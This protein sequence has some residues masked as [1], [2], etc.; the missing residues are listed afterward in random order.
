[1]PPLQFCIMIEF[2]M[3]RSIS[4]N[5]DFLRRLCISFLLL[6]LLYASTVTFS[7]TSQAA[8]TNTAAGLTSIRSVSPLFRNYGLTTLTS[9]RSA[10]DTSTHNRVKYSLTHGGLSPR[11]TGE[12]PAIL[13]QLL[14]STDRSALYL[15]C[16]L[17]RPGG[18]APPDFR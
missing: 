16:R 3:K 11:E 12:P 2:R 1:M 6:G 5:G 18:R 8:A 17:S 10:V 14:V 7:A 4:T 15:S 13:H 9:Q